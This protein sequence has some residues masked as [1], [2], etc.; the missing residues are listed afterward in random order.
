M[1]KSYRQ[2]SL[3]ERALLQVQLVLRWWPADIAP[4]RLTCV[5]SKP[6]VERKLVPGSALFL[7]VVERLRSGLSPD[8][9]AFTL[10]SMP[11]PVR[12]SHETLY[13]ALYAMQR[14][15]LRPP[16]C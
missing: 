16:A 9:I 11:D 8:Q 6:R 7:K 1:G 5:S 2:L 3:V 15:Q 4:K 13:T 10:R 12:L 14:G